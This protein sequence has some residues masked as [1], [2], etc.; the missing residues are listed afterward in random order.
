M[1][2]KFADIIAALYVALTPEQQDKFIETLLLKYT[3]E[4]IAEL[5]R[6]M[7]GDLT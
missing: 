5:P 6:A 4:D 7:D 2:I 3:A 1:N